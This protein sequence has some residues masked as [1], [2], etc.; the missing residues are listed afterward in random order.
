MHLMSA[1]KMHGLTSGE[2]PQVTQAELVL[3]APN[4][5]YRLSPGHSAHSWQHA[6]GQQGTASCDTATQLR[7]V[8]QKTGRQLDGMALA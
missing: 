4:C 8:T 7:G 5:C 6:H 3:I 2:F 1:S